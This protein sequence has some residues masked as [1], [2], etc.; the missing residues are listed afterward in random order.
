VK[1]LTSQLMATL[2]QRQMRRNIAALAKYVAVLTAFVIVYTIVFHALMV[3][4]GQDHSWLTGFY[5]TLTVMST[6]GFGDITFHTDLGRAFSILV[7]MTGIIL[8]LIV[9]PFAFI[10]YFYA[11]WLEAQIR[12]TAP[13]RAPEE[14]RDH[15]IICRYDALAESLIQRLK[16][17]GMQYLVVEPDPARALT[18]HNDG[19]RV[20]TGEWDSASTYEAAKVVDARLVV[21][22]LDDAA[23]TNVILTIREHH[24]S[25]RII[26][27]AE[28]KDAVD[29]LELAGATHVIPLKHRLGQQLAAR[30]SAGL[31]RAHAIGR[32]RDLVIAELPVHETNLE[33]RTI[34]ET[35]LREL[36]GLSIVAYWERGH[37]R[38]ARPDAVL[39]DHAG[40]VLVGTEE[41]LDTLNAMFSIYEPNDSPVVVLGGGKVGRATLRAL[42]ERQLAVNALEREAALE[43]LLSPIADDTII[44]DAADINK[45]RAA[46]VE[47][48]PSVVLSTHDDA[49]NIYLAVYCRKL[50]PDCRIVSRI[51]H[52]RN[53]E[54][55]HRAGA[56]FVLGETALGVRMVLSV[57]QNRE[58]I[59]I[60]EGVDVFVVDVPA[61]LRGQ[62]LAE[63][64][65]GAETGLSVIGLQKDGEV[66]NELTAQTRLEPH[67]KILLLGTN[68]QRQ[69]FRRI[70]E[71]RGGKRSRP[72]RQEPASPA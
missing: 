64:G 19:I 25:V 54:A 49:T 60:G 23:N 24:E 6:L 46:G 52:E 69:Q 35:R 62:T 30:V 55:I 59:V 37:L 45:I 65:I 47:R 33:G 50:N 11:P 9:L 5:W 42:K 61:T 26:A 53:H 71:R 29:I 66:I 15:V 36:T 3:Y 7:L 40:V 21:A 57:L 16:I 56:D 43:P 44:G 14:M 8:L 48:A 51:M 70:F 20:V 18:L 4:E 32:Y 28:D 10:R 68:D 13:R 41:Q 31:E 67:S 63:S 38:S 72:S 34:R 22:N 1:F 12:V 58:L 2:R 17:S 39:G 27:F